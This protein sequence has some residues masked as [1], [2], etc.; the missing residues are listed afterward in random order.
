MRPWRL[1]LAV[2]LMIVTAAS[3]SE[4]PLKLE[5][6]ARAS[7]ENI[8]LQLDG[9]DRR[10]LREHGPLRIGVS[11]HDYPPFELTRDQRVLEGLSADYA[12]MLGRLLGIPIQLLRYR[13]RDAA[14]R[15]LKS[16]ELDLLATSN[17]YEIADSELVL[18][19]AYAED[20]PMWVIPHNTLLPTA[21]TGKRIAMVEDY[22][23][24]SAVQNAYPSA[25]IVS[26]P[27][28]LHALGAVAFGWADLYLGDFISANYLINT[29][30]RNDLQLA[31]PAGLDA[32]PFAFALAR[33]NG[34]LKRNVDQALLAIPMEQR[35]IIEQRW[36]AGRADMSGQSKISLSSS[37]R[38]WLTRH[39]VVRVGAIDDFAPLTFFDAEGRLQGLSSQLLN[40]ISQRSGLTFEIVRGKSLDPQ[41]EQLQAR[42][43]DLL[44]VVAPSNERQ[45]VLRFTRD[46][47]SNPFVLVSASKAGSPQ[48]LDEMAGK[49]LAIYRGH[50]LRDYLLEHAPL[51]KLVEVQSPAA[52][53]EAI[54][55]GQADATVSSLM[56]ARYLIARQYRARM[57]IATTVGD[58]PAR[59]ALATA[60]D[61]RQL[62]SILNKAL[63]SISQQEMDDL[64]EL[65]SHDAPREGSY[66]D[67]HREEIARWFTGAALLLL[68]AL[69][70]I[71][72]QRR[73]IRQRQQW[74]QELQQAKQA[75]DDANRAKT[76]F[77]ASM[78]HEIR[79]PMSAVIG[80]LELARKRAD[81]GVTDHLAIEVAASAAQHVM[82]VIGDIL[83]IVQIEAGR[84]SL[85]PERANLRDVVLSVCRIFEGLAGEKS[86]RWNVDADPRSDIEVLIDRTRFMQV[87][88]NLL[89][90][91]IKFT[92]S[93]EVSL[94]LRVAAGGEGLLSV[95]V[96]VRDTGIGINAADLRQLFSP[97]VQVGNHPQA[98]RSGSGLGLAISRTLCEMMGGQIRL[99]SEPGRGTRASIQ[100]QLPIA[101]A[102]AADVVAAQVTAPQHRQFEVLVVDD[103][104]VNRLVLCLQLEE[105][106]HHTCSASDGSAALVLQQGRHFDAVITDINM[107]GI[108]GYEVAQAIREAEARAGGG[109]CLIL[110]YT[111]NAQVEEKQR[112]LDAGMDDCLIKPIRL[113]DLDR[114]LSRAI[115]CA[116]ETVRS[117]ADA[118][119]EI[120]LGPLRQLA[121]DD[122]SRIDRLLDEVLRSLHVDLQCLHDLS[123]QHD[124]AGLSDLAHHIQGGAQMVGA[125][126]VVNACHDLE[127]A[128]RN[129]ESV[130]LAT[131]V[132]A[133]R[134]AMHSLAQR[135]HS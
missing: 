96:F 49:R 18:S 131:A 27:S 74:L 44:P 92:D 135:I 83:D 58:Q 125:A 99:A 59:I 81:E 54:S 65:W 10:W 85:V 87:L 66:W 48:D 129:G 108:N 112:C 37:E 122:H 23:P 117:Q 15:A 101:S 134:E 98:P 77:L 57:R 39:P 115:P 106:G 73:Q 62:H 21:L 11:G 12:D 79:T 24:L 116:G 61:A 35:Q 36:S 71:A 14:M 91:A 53:M 55:K 31:G 89:S 30:Y 69:L 41:I 75:A 32:N 52:G 97:F 33:S 127:Q 26:Y 13:D 20:Q 86:L 8:H 16:G 28:I 47:L 76:T 100:V 124:H 2:L 5:L 50:P 6:L 34:R 107:R 38:E 82:E 72:F 103:N 114:A 130:A 95:S 56:V 119:A 126:R 67:E 88:S 40:L 133:L 102:R 4:A 80:T 45:Q 64:I 17:N 43:L 1:I 51:I 68:L 22:L 93:G 46:Y 104:S 7:P 9:R 70:W 118:S 42:K 90:N 25:V 3:A 29:N 63:L 111:A 109:R 78:S 105:L 60:P 84:M 19:R 132:D 94:Q 123:Q 121:G 113:D 128:C 120:D 110:G